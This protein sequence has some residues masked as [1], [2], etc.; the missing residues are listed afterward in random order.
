MKKI[1]IIILLL[2]V[3][4]LNAQ[5]KEATIVY[6]ISLDTIASLVKKHP[7]YFAHLQKKAS[8]LT[9]KMSQDEWIMLYYGSAFMPNFQPKKEEKAV[10]QVAHKM[11]ELDFSGAIKDAENLIKVY[12]VNARLYMLTGYAYK[13]IGEKQKSKKYYKRYADILRIPLYSGSGKEFAQAFVVRSTGDEYL[14]LNNKNLDLVQQEVRYHNRQPY[15]VMLVTDKINNH[16]KLSALPKTKLYFNI[17]LP[18]FIGE[19]H[20]YKE[21]QEEAKRKYHYKPNTAVYKKKK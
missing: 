1:R 6:G 15:D 17:Y 8:D 5:Q 13:K 4:Q 19:H 7:K 14:I 18:Y 9:Q 11:A 21:K 20:S 2:T 16:Q 3:F 10:E 12:P